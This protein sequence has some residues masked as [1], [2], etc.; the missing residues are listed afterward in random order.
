MQ[1]EMARVMSRLYS[2]SVTIM[3]ADAAW[4]AYYKE[5]GKVVASGL[6]DEEVLSAVKRQTTRVENNDFLRAS[7]HLTT[8]LALLYVAVEGWRKWKFFDAVVDRLLDSPLVKEL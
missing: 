8:C 5:M 7:A 3:S 2:L 4:E 6:S 1:A